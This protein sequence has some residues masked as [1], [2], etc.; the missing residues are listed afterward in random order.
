TLTGLNTYSGAT[1]VSGGTLKVSGLGI[2]ASAAYTVNLG[3]TLTVDNTTTN[4]INRLPIASTLALNGG[5][6]SFLGTNV[7]NTNSAQTI[8]AVILN[9]GH[10]VIS[11]T[12]GTGGTTILTAGAL[13]RIAGATVDFV[14]SGPNGALGAGSNTVIFSSVPGA[15]GG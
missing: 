9:S 7:A 6:F 15:V 14:G 12:T 3:G 2:L 10:S 4:I 11:S 8:G 5:T 1:T 13:S